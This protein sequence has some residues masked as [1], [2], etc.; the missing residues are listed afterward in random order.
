MKTKQRTLAVLLVLVLVLGG[1]LWFVSRSNAAEE[2][3]SS[4]AAEGSILLSSFAA[5]D[6]TSIRYAYGGETLTLNYDSGSWTL[7]DDPD[8]H[9]DASAC[10]TMVTALASLNAKRQ[11]TA[12]PGEDYGLADPAVT[13]TV[14]AAGETNRVFSECVEWIAA[15]SKQGLGKMIGAFRRAIEAF[16]GLRYDRS[17]RKPRVLVTGELLVTFHPGT[18]FHVEE[19]LERNDMEVILPRITYQF[20]KDFQAAISEIRDFGAHLAPYP[21]A[22]DGAVEFIQRFLERIARSHPLYHPAARPQDLYSDVEHFIPKTLTCGE[23]W[24]MA[25]EIAHYAHQGVRSFI[26]LQP[27]GCLPNHVCGRGVTKRLKE[28]FP[29]VQILPLD[30]DPDTSYANVENRLQMLIM[31]QTAEAEHSAASVEPAPQKTRGG[32]PR[33][34]LSST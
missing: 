29:G 17:R 18:N 26:I 23:G 12:Q 1:L 27:F 8:Y 4:A 19:Y 6:V 16:R 30:L 31:N 7:A 14:T 21:F 2:T 28:E 5:G 33:P 34:A 15:A 20:R 25:G 22:L 10:N 32:S 11:L 3:A 13:V 9:L 24:L